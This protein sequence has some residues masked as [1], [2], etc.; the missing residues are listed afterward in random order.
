MLTICGQDSTVVGCQCVVLQT[1]AAF[2]ESHHVGFRKA[3]GTKVVG[4]NATWLLHD[5][6]D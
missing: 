6:A 4:E 1:S 2:F 3:R 5:R